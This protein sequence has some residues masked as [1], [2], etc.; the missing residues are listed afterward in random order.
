MYFV[1]VENDGTQDDIAC[2]EQWDPISM[3]EMFC[4]WRRRST[5][6]D[7]F[8]LDEIVTSAVW[9]AIDSEATVLIPRAHRRSA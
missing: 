2:V 6:H 7:F 8:F 1:S 3:N 9:R 4:K 5:N